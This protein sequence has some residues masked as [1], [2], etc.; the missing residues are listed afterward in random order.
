MTEGRDHRPL[1]PRTAPRHLRDQRRDPRVR[2]CDNESAGLRCREC[3]AAPPNAT[4]PI[5][6]SASQQQVSTRCAARTGNARIARDAIEVSDP[7]L[8]RLVL[9]GRQKLASMKGAAAGPVVSL[10]VSDSLSHATVGRP[11]SCSPRPTAT[12]S[13]HGPR[14]RKVTEAQA[15]VRARRM[16]KAVTG[17]G[18]RC[19]VLLSDSGRAQMSS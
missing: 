12:L 5:E 14:M 11:R 18:D 10:L 3:R 4:R 7:D 9:A 15:R 6:S 2:C 13:P 1:P 17:A 16:L 8:R 19:R